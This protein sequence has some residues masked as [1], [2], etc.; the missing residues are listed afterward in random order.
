MTY[1]LTIRALLMKK[2]IFS[3]RQLHIAPNNF[4]ISTSLQELSGCRKCV[5][6]LCEVTVVMALS[7]IRTASC[8]SCVI[9]EEDLLQPLYTECY[10]APVRSQWLG[11]L[12]VVLL[13]GFRTWGRV[14]LVEGLL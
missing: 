2:T 6:Q 13:L 11:E 3:R 8:T 4:T 7:S 12:L 10:N 14:S 5:V 1:E 9:T